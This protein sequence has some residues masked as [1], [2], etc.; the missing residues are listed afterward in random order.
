MSGIPTLA[1]G[2]AEQQALEVR[3]FLD[4]RSSLL[5]AIASTVDTFRINVEAATERA[6]KL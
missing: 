6:L 2:P 4:E 5:P 3:R 1:S